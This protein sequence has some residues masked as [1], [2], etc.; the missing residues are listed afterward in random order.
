[1]R[2][3]GLLVLAAA[4]AAD[5]PADRTLA[6]AKAYLKRGQEAADSA[7]EAKSTGQRLHA[8][9]RAD[10]FLSRADQLAAKTDDLGLQSRARVSLVD[11]RVRK[12]AVLYERKSL[13]QAKETVLSALKLDP[14]NAAAKALLAAIEKAEEDDLFDSVDGLVA[15]DRVKARRLAAGAPLRDRGA[16]RRR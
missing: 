10:F 13:P 15:I 5:V 4:V 8:L 1:M 3:L 14:E 2:T 7:R 12:A 6:L 11:A 16:A 9:T